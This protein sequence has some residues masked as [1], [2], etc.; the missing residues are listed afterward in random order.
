[1]AVAPS[2]QHTVLRR[3]LSPFPS[4]GKLLATEKS[5]PTGDPS[6]LLY[7]LVVAH[8]CLE[9]RCLWPGRL[10]SILQDDVAADVIKIGNLVRNKERFIKRRQRLIGPNGATLKAIEL[11]TECYVSGGCSWTKLSP[12]LFAGG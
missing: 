3:P 6:P 10:R 9:P 7:L 12:N 5:L 1:M 2:R 4:R 8:P 11:L